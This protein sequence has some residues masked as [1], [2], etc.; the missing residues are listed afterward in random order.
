MIFNHILKQLS[1]ADF[2]LLEPHLQEEQLPVRKQL[3][4]K[5]D[6]VRQVC[7]LESGIA[8]VVANG[9][10]LSKSAWSIA[11]AWTRLCWHDG[12]VPKETF[13]QIAGCGLV[14]GTEELTA[15]IRKSR[16]LHDILRARLPDADHPNGAVQ[17]AQHDGTTPVP[18]A[19]AGAWVDGDELHWRMSFWRP[20]WVCN[21]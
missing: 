6:R 21:A 2:G 3:Q 17:W 19:A 12:R 5:N 10:M 4:A 11:K 14:L 15:A 7:F 1:A 18:L 16:T 8:S 9:T 13:M 20:C